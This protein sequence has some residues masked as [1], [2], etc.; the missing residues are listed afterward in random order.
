MDYYEQIRTSLKS[1]AE[2]KN[3]REEILKN[4]LDTF[5]QGG[6]EAVTGA[7]KSRLDEMEEELKEK[8]DALKKML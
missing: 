8:L 4:I 2:E 7:M 6:A 3:R 5:R 1:R